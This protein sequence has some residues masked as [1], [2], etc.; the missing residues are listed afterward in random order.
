MTIELSWT[1]KKWM[2]NEKKNQSPN[3]TNI[4]LRVFSQ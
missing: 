3:T 2:T 1:T 4:K